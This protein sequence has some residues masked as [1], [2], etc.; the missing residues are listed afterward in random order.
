ME[1]A[2]LQESLFNT[3]LLQFFLLATC[4]PNLIA[5]ASATSEK[6]PLNKFSHYFFFTQKKKKRKGIHRHTFM[7][8]TKTILS[9]LMTFKFIII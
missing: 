9:F 7:N 4:I 5:E 8:A 1:D 2:F 3:T 6:Q